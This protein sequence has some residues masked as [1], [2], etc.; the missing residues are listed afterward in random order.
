VIE[1]PAI[2]YPVNQ[3]NVVAKISAPVRQFYVNR[4]DHVKQ[5][6]RLA[7]LEN[8]DLEA[9]AE[10]TKSL[11]DQAAAAFQNTTAATMPEDLTKAQADVE[12]TRQALEAARKVFESRQALVREGALAQ[13]LADDAKVAMVQAQSQFDTAQKHLD[14]LQRVGRQEQ[15]K[16]AKAQLD[17]AKARNQNAVAQL[18]Y[19]EVRSP[20]NGIVADRP[21]YAGEMPSSGSPLISIMDISQVVARA[22]VPVADAAWIRVGKA[23]MIS[24]PGGDVAGK[25]TVVSPAVNPN[26]TTVE[27]WVQAPNPGERIKPGVTARVSISAETIQAAIIVPAAALL[28]SDEGGQKV[29]VVGADSLAH[30]KKIETGVREGD[31][32]EV[33]KGLTEGEQVITVGGLG[34][35]D[36]AKVKIESAGTGDHA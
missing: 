6:D 29:M 24:A 34:L 10:E 19:A 17:A 15:I 22:N 13:K 26:T 31:K 1:A 16:G 9:S 11:Y 20:I 23:A 21:V 7:L 36:K 27:I 25:V 8:R 5:G 32:V 14:S 2:L 18:S 4:G 28:S 33:T 30:E 35:E 12:S 3:A